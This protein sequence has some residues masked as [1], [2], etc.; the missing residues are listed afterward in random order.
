[1]SAGYWI[2]M[3]KK[4]MGA[5]KSSSS[6]QNRRPFTSGSRGNKWCWVAPRKILGGRQRERE[7]K[8]D[9]ARERDEGHR[10]A[11]V[12]KPFS[13]FTH[14]T[15]Y[16]GVRRHSLV[17]TDCTWT[18]WV[19]VSRVPAHN[20]LP[21]CNPKC[22]ANPLDCNVFFRFFWFNQFFTPFLVVLLFWKVNQLF[23]QSSII[24]FQKTKTKN[25]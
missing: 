25:I 21:R 23:H 11:N 22:P 24:E 1:M 12:Y 3:T 14:L 6:L 5:V 15:H 2:R 17:R 9:N 16:R 10:T 7:T 4:T 13:S 20:F 8:T 19:S 18:E